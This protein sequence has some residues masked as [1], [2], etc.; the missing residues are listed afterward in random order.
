M[1]QQGMAGATTVVLVTTA[2]YFD[3]VK[4]QLVQNLA[5]Q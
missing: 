1:R 5:T 2:A 3:A 4:A